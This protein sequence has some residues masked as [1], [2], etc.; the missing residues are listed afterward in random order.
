M[1]AS[2]TPHNVFGAAGHRVVYNDGGTEKTATTQPDGSLSID[3]GGTV[4][5]MTA[6]QQ[7]AAYGG[8]TTSAGQWR[9]PGGHRPT[10]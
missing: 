5:A 7:A 9:W 10:L 1:R 2:F 3:G 6:E 8:A 4:A